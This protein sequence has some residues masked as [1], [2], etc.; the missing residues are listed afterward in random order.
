[1][2]INK[3]MIFKENGIKSDL[4][5]DLSKKVERQKHLPKLRAKTKEHAHT[6]LYDPNYQSVDY[7]GVEEKYGIFNVYFY[8]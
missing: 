1:M 5:S 8:I 4:Y 7:D 6:T 2:N 3:T